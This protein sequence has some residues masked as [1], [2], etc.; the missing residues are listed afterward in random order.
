MDGRVDFFVEA[1]HIAVPTYVREG[2]CLLAQSMERQSATGTRAGGDTVNGKN[3]MRNFDELLEIAAERHGG[4][5]ALERRLSENA[6]KQDPARLPDDRWLAAMTRHVFQ[7]GFNWKV[8]EAMW[9][10]FETAFRGF[11]PDTVA[12]MSE[13]WFDELLT[14]RRIV[15]NGAKIQ[16]VQSNAVFVRDT[17]RRYGGFGRHVADWPSDDFA[18]LLQWLKAEGTRLGGTTAQYMLR[19]MGVDGY[20]LSRD[21]VGRLI[22]EGSFADVVDSAEVRASYLGTA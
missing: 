17:S 16:S 12:A 22:A 15:R 13:D 6:P 7:A 9:S 10:G 4:P 20:V 14:D 2:G 8:V 1:E 21:V 5:D 18:G 19:S 11:D 3:S